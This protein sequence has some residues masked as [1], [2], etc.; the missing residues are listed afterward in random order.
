MSSELIN[1]VLKLTNAERTQAGLQPLKLNSPLINAAQD[2]SDDM[3]EDDFFSHT[4][5]DGSSVGDRVQESGYQYSTV[6][7]NIAAGQRTAAEVVEAWMNSPGHRANIL[8]PDFTEIGVGYAFLETDTGSVNYNHYWTQVFGTSLKNNAGSES[9]LPTSENLDSTPVEDAGNNQQ[10]IP[11][12]NMNNNSSDVDELTGESNG[13]VLTGGNN[14]VD[15]NPG[16]ETNNQLTDN[17]WYNLPD[18]LND[19]YLGNETNINHD[20]EVI[21]VAEYISNSGLEE[22]QQNTI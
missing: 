11:T 9:E 15:F 7:E 6:G 10:S 20:D 21:D 18:L 1:Q 19:L 14:A 22:P 2:H 4:G 5:V 16:G 3:A 8:N 13:S 12:E 17:T